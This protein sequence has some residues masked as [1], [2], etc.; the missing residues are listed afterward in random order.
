[1][2]EQAQKVKLHT[3]LLPPSYGSSQVMESGS[4]M[5][6]WTSQVTAGLML[7]IR[8]ANCPLVDHLPGPVAMAQEVIVPPISTLLGLLPLQSGAELLGLFGSYGIS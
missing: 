4:I 5:L 6:V 7:V 8:A 1:M 2:A 3:A